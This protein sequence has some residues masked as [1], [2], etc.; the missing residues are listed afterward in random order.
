MSSSAF[1]AKKQSPDD[2]LLRLSDE[3]MEMD[4]GRK[5]LGIGLELNPMNEA[6]FHLLEEDVKRIINE[7]VTKGVEDLAKLKEKW[8]REV[9]ERNDSLERTME[10]NG[11][12]ESDKLN[13]KLDAIVGKFLSDTSESRERTHRLA[14][15]D[16][17]KA[18]QEQREKEKKKYKIQNWDDTNDEWDTW[19]DWKTCG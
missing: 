10:M 1:Q 2:E 8:H 15:E 7:K 14:L 19:D 18:K 6:E 13:L 5:S 4:T 11:K 12:R 9:Q 17:E 16:E 3:D